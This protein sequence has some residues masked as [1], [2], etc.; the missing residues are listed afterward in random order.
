MAVVSAAVVSASAG[1]AGSGATVSVA[2]LSCV[3]AAVSEGF[4]EQAA[5]TANTATAKIDAILIFISQMV[6]N[7]PSYK[8]VPPVT[9]YFSGLKSFFHGLPW[10]F[11]CIKSTL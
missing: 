8:K 3:S 4:E 5:A 9:Q 10:G 11:V 2:T 1:A 7:F 6:K